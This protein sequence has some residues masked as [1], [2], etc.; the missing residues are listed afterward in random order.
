MSNKKMSHV[1]KNGH[2]RMVDIGSKS[3]IERIA[4]ASAVVLVSPALLKLL[5]EN[6]LEK[7][8]ALA[9]ARTAGIMAAKKTDQLIPLCHSLPLTQVSIDLNLVDDPPSVHILTT[10]KTAYKTGVEMEALTAA[11]VA[12]LT[13]YDMSKAVDRGIIIERIQ[14][15]SKAG[16]KSGDWKRNK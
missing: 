15:E 13:I 16:G 3:E 1:D 5:K 4:T 11:S 14:L 12:A 6:G 7:G 8:D 9:I 10:A 2:A